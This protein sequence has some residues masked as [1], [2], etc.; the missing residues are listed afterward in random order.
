MIS[1]VKFSFN[2]DVS[3]A[4]SIIRVKVNAE[5]L[6]AERGEFDYTGSVKHAVIPYEKYH[7]V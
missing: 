1:D 5:Q 2:G 6:I 4:D 7:F 3:N